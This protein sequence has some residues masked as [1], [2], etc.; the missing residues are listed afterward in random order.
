MVLML[1]HLL[2]NKQVVLV[3]LQD[4]QQYTPLVVEVVVVEM[5]VVV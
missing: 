4:L 5:V 3:L 2:L 1:L